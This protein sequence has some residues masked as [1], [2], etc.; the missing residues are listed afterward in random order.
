MTLLVIM[1]PADT[2]PVFVALTGRMTPRERR[3][4]VVRGVAAAGALVVGFAF[5]GGV[6]LGALGVSLDSLSVAGGLLL[7]LV[8]LERLRGIDVA[9]AEEGDVAL[10]PLATPLVAGPGA[11]ATVIVLARQ[12]PEVAVVGGHSPRSR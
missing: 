7:L 5:F 10:V 6:L 3:W 2:A 9:S 4:A 12:R 8:A 11:I 1:D